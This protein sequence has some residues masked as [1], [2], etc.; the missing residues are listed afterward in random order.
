MPVENK[1]IADF[2]KNRTERTGKILIFGQSDGTITNNSK[3]NVFP[4]AA[5]DP[6]CLQIPEKER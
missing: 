5:F 6:G 4:L 1:T 2:L 3:A